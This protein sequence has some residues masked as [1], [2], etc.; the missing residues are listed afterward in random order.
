LKLVRPSRRGLAATFAL[1]AIAAAALLGFGGASAS[2]VGCPSFRVLHNDRIGPASFPAGPYTLTPDAGSGL[3]CA[4]TSALFAR[5]LDDWDGNLP[6]SWRVIAQGSGKARFVNGANAA[7]TVQRN[8]GER[9]EEETNPAIGKLCPG[10]YVV[11]H[12]SVVGPLRFRRGAYLIYLPARSA[13][14]CR[15]ASVLFTR[16]LGQPG[17]RLPF[18]W[19]VQTQTATFYK[20]GRPVRS[21]FR[22]ETRAGVR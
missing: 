15:R 14:T 20:Q 19:L 11:N 13:I 12:T 3:T 9:E 17:G 8:G 10:N 7:F 5:F 2:A 22:L 4:R 16:F 21:A 18:P 1:A 6:G